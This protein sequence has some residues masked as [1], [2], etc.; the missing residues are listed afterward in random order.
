MPLPLAQIVTVAVSYFALFS[1]PKL[2]RL[3]QPHFHPHA[4]SNLE[5]ALA[6]NLRGQDDAAREIASAICDHLA[7]P[8]PQRPLAISLHGPPG[9]GKSLFHLLAARALYGLSRPG[10]LRAC[11]GS[12]CPGYDVVYG[13][14]F[15]PGAEGDAQWRAVSERLRQHMQDY[16]ESLVVLEEYDRMPCQARR[17][18]RRL[19]DHGRALNATAPRSIVILESNLGLGLVQKLA[20][21]LRAGTVTREAS[22]RALKELVFE[23]WT[24]GDAAGAQCQDD[25]GGLGDDGETAR[26]L[27]MV[28]H[29]VPFLPLDRD[30]VRE[31]ARMELDVWAREL[32]QRVGLALSWPRELE[33]WIAA[34]VEYAGEFS[35][36]GGR[37]VAPLVTRYVSVAIRRELAR[38]GLSLNVKPRDRQP[39]RGTVE[40]TVADRNTVRAHVRMGAA[41]VAGRAPEL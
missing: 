2:L 16:P 34:R 8:A 18:L 7:D 3:G 6:A 22:Q 36:E 17:V 35:V 25:G 5:A 37:E 1:V 26:A 40:L 32:R 28:R 4:C 20:S 23:R 33:A 29:F 15:A 31:I 41:R 19:I 13:V 12:S 39:Q 21:G 24:G 38:H 27:S 10:E 9:V 14:D 11:P 30:A